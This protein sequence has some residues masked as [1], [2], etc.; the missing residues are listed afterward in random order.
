MLVITGARAAPHG[1]QRRVYNG[2]RRLQQAPAST[3]GLKKAPAGSSTLQLAP[4]GSSKLQQAP[5]GS[6]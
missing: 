4:S 6:K 2:S 3:S 5:E 1:L